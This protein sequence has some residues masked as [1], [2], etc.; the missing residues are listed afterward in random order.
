[1]QRQ[2]DSASRKKSKKRNHDEMVAKD[3]IGAIEKIGEKAIGAIE[4]I[5][6][7]EESKHKHKH[8]H[9]NKKRRLA[10]EA[11][12]EAAFQARAMLDALM[13]PP[14]PII[15]RGFTSADTDKMSENEYFRYDVRYRKPGMPPKKIAHAVL[16]GDT[17]LQFAI[18]P[19]E[20]EETPV[21]R[22]LEDIEEFVS[23]GAPRLRAHTPN[24]TQMFATR[25]VN[26]EFD[27]EPWRL[28]CF[29]PPPE[30]KTLPFW[31]SEKEVPLLRKNM[32]EKEKKELQKELAEIFA[33]NK[34]AN[35]E[36]LGR[37]ETS[38][39]KGGT[40]L[41]IDPDSVQIRDGISTRIPDQNTVMGESA[42]EAYEHFLE[43][44][45]EVL[46][47]EMKMVLARAKDAHLKYQPGD[48]P[49][50]SS[51]YRPEWGH[52]E[53]FSL[54]PRSKDPQVKENL[55]A[56]PKWANTEMMV[57]E[58]T[59]KW[60]ALH[61]PEAVETI[62][63]E[64]KMLLDSELVDKIKYV[65]KI[66]ENG[67][68]FALH[69]NINPLKQWPVFTQPTDT[70]QTIAISHFMLDEAPVASKSAIK[71]QGKSRGVTKPGGLADRPVGAVEE[72][73]RVDAME[74]EEP[75][76]EKAELKKGDDVMRSREKK[77]E[78]KEVENKAKKPEKKV[79]AP[80]VDEMKGD[81]DI[82]EVRYDRSVMQIEASS[83]EYDYDNPWN[84][85]KFGECSGSAWVIEHEGKKY[86]MTNAHVVENAT[87]L[88]GRF[89]DDR[90][91][92]Y[93]AKV[94]CVS[95]QCDLAM[96]EIDDE[97]FQQRAEPLVL[98]EMPK[99][100]QKVL[101]VGFPMG[102]NEVN[103]SEGTVSR[104]ES[105][106][107][108]MSGQEMLAVGLTA[109]INPGNSGGPVFS[110]GR[111]I[112]VAFQGYVH[113]QG[114]GYMIPIPI[115]KHFLQEVFSGKQYRGF[116]VIPFQ[117]QHLDSPLL[118][119]ACGLKEGQT[120]VRVM[121]VHAISKAHEKLKTGDVLLSIDGL[122]ISNEGTVSIQ[123]VGKV[124]NMLHV[125]HSKFI[126]DSVNFKIIRK[127]ET[128]QQHEE[129]EVTVELD[130][131]PLDTTKVGPKEHDK[132]PTYYIYS[133]ICFEPLTL[134]FIE[135]SERS[136]LEGA[137]DPATGMSVCDIAK[138]V[139]GQQIVV[140][141]D[142]WSCTQTRGYSGLINCTIKKVNGK[143][144]NNIRELI[145]AFENHRGET[146]EIITGGGTLICL[147]NITQAEK[148]II[149][150]QHG[151][152]LEKDRSEDLK[153]TRLTSQLKE[154]P[155]P[156]TPVITAAPKVVVPAVK[157]APVIVKPTPVRANTA[158]VLKLIAPLRLSESSSSSSEDSSSSE[159]SELMS[160]LEL[161]EELPS[162][163]PVV[164]KKGQL[165]VHDFT[166]V[167]H[168]RGAVDRIEKQ[169]KL[170]EDL[171]FED[172][173][174][175][176][177]ELGEGD[178]EESPEEISEAS[179]EEV[180]VKKR[181]ITRLSQHHAST[182]ASSRQDKRKHEDSEEDKSRDSKRFKDQF[183]RKK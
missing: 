38:L 162:K 8:K 160:S 181:P 59:I 52:L 30:N 44:Y 42:K 122:P 2:E 29:S 47:E 40:E 3:A 141:N 61:R 11:D 71:R 23:F 72:V 152:A 84:P 121:S 112:G 105:G 179:S 154:V 117:Y 37:E 150:G 131:V 159:E 140:I 107:Y 66:E 22:P 34:A 43:K 9:K 126:G 139:P 145:S 149:F 90:E 4:E 70:M 101:V 147:K 27:G 125:T 82:V 170:M 69:Q 158:G 133:G 108:S 109:A 79:K 98:G 21:I 171:G 161:P 163:K 99:R 155:K 78:V 7:A 6:V 156:A 110:S 60:T 73:E 113:H 136:D 151:V 1:M 95:Y 48:K 74:L 24:G 57:A 87:F 183:G 106:E 51:Q 138:T 13:A 83:V 104:I 103:F 39:I 31:G 89:A 85:G 67:H 53:G 180:E 148:V 56:M 88:T 165:N 80:V 146:H 36:R 130:S 111:V 86:V 182:F 18:P 62:K 177:D 12:T 135:D 100:Q 132:P 119:K 58:R 5:E 144:I 76:L 14:Q 75:V 55:G 33:A 102:G 54:T 164:E 32:K 115:V 118:A 64:F 63:A 114:L 153:D 16:V 96:L 41:V 123:G 65:A 173:E 124:I 93:I 157:A 143:E 28:A 46:S 142:V 26:G 15:A 176:V 35:K 167:K 168:F 94:K 129:L 134:N 91:K 77:S 50:H 166:G 175:H 20:K 120:G 92:K 68:T 25:Y 19:G 128:T 137:R 127:N 81:G 116:P 174:I 45:E 49:S 172:E 10:S 17:A 97:E 169:N 178:S